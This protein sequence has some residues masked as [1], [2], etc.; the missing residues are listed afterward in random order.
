VINIRVKFKIFRFNHSRDM[1][2]SQHFKSRSRDLFTAPFNLILHFLIM[3]YILNLDV[4]FDANIFISDRLWLFTT[5]P[6]WLRNAYCR[7]FWGGFW[8]FDP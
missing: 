4:K 7:P 5:S 8:E 3:A 6:I 1:E 2:G